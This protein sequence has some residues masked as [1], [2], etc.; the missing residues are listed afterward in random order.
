MINLE[1]GE[2]V[3]KIII[4]D[5]RINNAM[6]KIVIAIWSKNRHELLFWWRIPVEF[7]GVKYSTGKNF[8]KL[9]TKKDWIDTIIGVGTW[10]I[11]WAI[12]TTLLNYFAGLG[13]ALLTNAKGVK[14]KKLWR[15]LFILPYAIPAFISLLIFRLVFS[16]PGPVNS[17]LVNTGILSNKIPFFSFEW[18]VLL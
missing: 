10:T 11:L 17:L 9:I 3:L 4:Q 12:I 1:K 5:I 14:F 15:T 16:G 18:I 7:K 6:V 2:H 8:L 13:L